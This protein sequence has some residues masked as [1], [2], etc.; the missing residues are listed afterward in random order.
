M[1]LP[2]IF[3]LMN[4]NFCFCHLRLRTRQIEVNLPPLVM[5]I[6][7]LTSKTGKSGHDYM[8]IDQSSNL[9]RLGILSIIIAER[10]RERERERRGEMSVISM[11]G[12]AL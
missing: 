8:N 12:N 2:M 1:I 9:F 3:L 10:E 7:R 4:M 11:Y 6:S 5:K